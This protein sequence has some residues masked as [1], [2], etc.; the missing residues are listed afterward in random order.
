MTFEGH[1]APLVSAGSSL[2]SIKSATARDAGPGFRGPELV[3]LTQRFEADRDDYGA[4][5]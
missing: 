5:P 4:P 2:A 3:S 1:V